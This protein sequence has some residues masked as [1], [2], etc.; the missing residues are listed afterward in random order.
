LEL[1]RHYIE[2][3]EH[4]RRWEEM[5]EKTERLLVGV[6]RSIDEMKGVQQVSP[7]GSPSQQKQTV[8]LQAGAPA[9]GAGGSSAQPEGEAAGPAPVAAAS[10]PLTRAGERSKESVWPTVAEPVAPAEHA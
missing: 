10:V 6:K 5:M 2:L 3:Q 1:E 7:S 4:K 9:P 8:P